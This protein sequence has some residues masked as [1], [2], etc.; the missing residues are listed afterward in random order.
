MKT[1]LLAFPPLQRS[2][3]QSHARKRNLQKRG[4][5][6]CLFR[7]PLLM[8]Y[9]RWALLVASL[10]LALFFHFKDF[11]FLSPTEGANVARNLV[12]ANFATAIFIRQQETI[13][14]LFRIATSMPPSWPLSL[15]WAAGKVY[16]FGG[17]HVGAFFSGFCWM[18]LQ[19]LLIRD[20]S[21][22][23][24][25]VVHLS[26]L[27]IMITMALPRIRSRFHNQFE[28][29]GR[30]GL[31]TSLYL[32]WVQTI[33]LHLNSPQ[34]SGA[35]LLTTLVLMLATVSVA[36]PW[37]RLRRVRVDCVTPS[38]HVALAA[39]S[40]GVKPF[41]GSSTDLSRS[42][43]LEWHSFANVPHPTQ[44]GFRLTISRAGDWT[45][46]LIDQKPRDLWVK[47]I[48]VA[49]VGHVEKLF[50]RVVWIATGSGIG[51]CLPHLF[52]KEVPAR[53]IWSTRNPEKTYGHELVQEIYQSQPEAVIWDTDAQGKPDLV[54]LALKAYQD[55]DAEAVICISN[56]K[57][58]WHV[59]HEL[60]SRGIPAFG[61][62][63][64][65]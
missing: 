7:H 16:H 39:F 45:G 33:Y 14:L 21:L 64:D 2:I 52:S 12:L 63:W 38:S 10:N 1:A 49:G 31:W 46:R 55:F 19:A 59:V 6:Y 32:F 13:N 8:P 48:P 54:K 35:Q 22:F 47:G 24:L 44:E 9:N 4:F 40:Y 62:I 50:K 36:L 18:G 3:E 51:P 28:I 34:V 65:S 25:L 58:T 27:L 23:R 30:F 42:P 53:L 11:L 57:V 37:L 56:K 20:L 29:V 17:I 41:A 5:L 26:V 60:E 43:W 61:A 15:R